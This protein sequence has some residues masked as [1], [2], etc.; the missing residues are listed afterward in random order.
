MDDSNPLEVS[1]QL[2][3]REIYQA[4][5][6]IALG[7]YTLHIWLLIAVLFATFL[8]AFFEVVL[9]GASP[10]HSV[11]PVVIFGLIFVPVF[12][13]V[14]IFGHSYIAAMALFRGNPSLQGPTQWTFCDTHDSTNGPAGKTELPWKIYLRARETRNLFLL[15]VQKDLANVIPKRSF[16]DESDIARFRALL[17]NHDLPLT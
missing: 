1:F 5:V 14:M 12:L 6:S 3:Q 16:A 17:A 15:Y 13:V 2:T 8:G 10:A 4:N 11:K 9:F 7:R